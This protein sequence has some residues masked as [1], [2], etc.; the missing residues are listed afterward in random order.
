M[1]AT[2]SMRYMIILYD[3]IYICIHTHTHTHTH[4]HMYIGQEA[5]MLNMGPMDKLLALNAALRRAQKNIHEEDEEGEEWARA[6][7]RRRVRD[8]QFVRQ[9]W[10]DAIVWGADPPPRYRYSGCMAASRAPGRSG[11]REGG[12]VLVLPEVWTQYLEVLPGV[13]KV[14]GCVYVCIYISC[15]YI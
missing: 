9:A 11:G 3:M 1:Y 4:T 8:T 13:Q 15:V 12:D 5:W 10:E 14:V 6:Y 7:A 2:P